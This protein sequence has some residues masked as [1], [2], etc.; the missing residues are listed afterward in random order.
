MALVEVKPIEYQRWHGKKSE[1]SFHKPFLLRALVDRNTSTYATGLTASQ[2]ARLSQV[3]RAD[4]SNSFNPDVPHPFWDLNILGAVKLENKTNI[5]DTSKPHDEI[6]VAIMK[7]SKFVANSVQEYEEGHYP[8]AKF[9]IYD[10]TDE[11]AKKEKA[12]VVRKNLIKRLDAMVRVKK[13]EMLRILMGNSYSEQS[14]DYIDMKV[15]EC[16]DTF[17]L[18]EVQEILDRDER[19]NFVHA[20]LL[21]ALSKSVVRKEGQSVFYFS[22]RIGYNIAEAIQFLLDDN[23]STVLNNIVSQT[24]PIDDRNKKKLLTEEESKKNI[25]IKKK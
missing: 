12:Y 20:L 21:E 11:L 13:E 7:A 5:F 15:M 4:L 22:D 23:N 2:E 25:A 17:S 9:V 6:K 19:Y 10:K 3:L 14:N 1:E 18:E 8:Y 16:L 24:R